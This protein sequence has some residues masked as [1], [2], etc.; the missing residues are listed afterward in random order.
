MEHLY[1]KP[2]CIISLT[3]YPARFS[4]LPICLQSLF[5]Q[6]F[7]GD[8]IILYLD[9]DVPDSEI[10]RDIKNFTRY[11]LKII[12]TDDMLKS[13]TKY[14]YAMQDYPDAVIVTVDDDV[15]YGEKCIETL[16]S[17]YIKNPYSVS[18]N[19]VHHILYGE[20]GNI[21]PYLNWKFEETTEFMPSLELFA[22]GV[23]G[24]LY[25]PGLLSNM[26]FNKNYIK[27]FCIYA[28]DIW[29]KFMELLNG[30]T[31][32]YSGMNPPHPKQIPG[33]KETSLFQYN[34]A[35]GINDQCIENLNRLFSKNMKK[36]KLL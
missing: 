19:R 8:E 15:I 11:G 35:N 7:M 24:V 20:D 5:Q 21:L 34:K 10:P 33:T 12:Q 23:G 30:I 32:V 26:I 2:K 13:H 9:K 1:I 31:V 14:Y 4:T 28:D 16:F 36:G 17:S 3:S 29:L 6:S 27:K 22:T 18:A 25:P